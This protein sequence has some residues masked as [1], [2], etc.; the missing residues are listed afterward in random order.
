MSLLTP[1]L[2][3]YVGKNQMVCILSNSTP[4]VFLVSG[5]YHLLDCFVKTKY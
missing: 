3:F 1:K 2:K 4:L 5:S